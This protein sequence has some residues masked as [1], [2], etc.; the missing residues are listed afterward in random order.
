MGEVHYVIRFRKSLVLLLVASAALACGPAEVVGS[1]AAATRVSVRVEP[2]TALVAP[3]GSVEFKA[4]LTGAAPVALSWSADCGLVTQDGVYTAPPS[5]GTC[6]VTATHVAAGVSGTA[7]VSVGEGG[8]AARCATEPLRSTG[9]IYYACDCQT[10]AAAGCS[11]GND[12]NPGTSPGAPLRTLSAASSKFR[13]MNAGDTVALCAGGRFSAVADNWSA[14]VNLACTPSS[15]CILRD[16]PTAWSSERPVVAMPAAGERAFA[17][18]GKP[19]LVDGVRFLNLNLVGNGS[20]VG[21]GFGNNLS[22]WEFCNLRVQGFGSGVQ[23]SLDGSYDGTTGCP[24][25]P[26]QGRRRHF[27][28]NQIVDNASFGVLYDGHDSDWDGNYFDNN[29]FAAG[30]RCAAGATGHTFYIDSH[31]TAQNVRF[32]NNEVYR[33]AMY[34]GYPQGTSIQMGGGSMGMVI[35]NNFVDSGP[36]TPF[37]CTSGGIFAKTAGYGPTF[38]HELLVIRGNWLVRG[39][40]TQIGVSAAPD[41]LIENN[42]IVADGMSDINQND[43]ISLRSESDGLETKAVVRNNTLYLANISSASRRSGIAIASLDA[44]SGNIVTGNTITIV[45]EAGAPYSASC[46]RAADLSKIAFMNNNHCFGTSTYARVG[47]L[48]DGATSYTLESWRVLTGFDADSITADPMFTNA[49]T[50]LTPSAT[51]PLVGAAS[52][53]TCT[54]QGVGGQ[55]CSST[56]AGPSPTWNPTSRAETRTGSPFDIGAFER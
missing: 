30:N 50:D 49:P 34:N 16:Y 18:G 54:I 27:R 37:N 23:G 13:A 51:S 6:R 45:G 43:V 11:P 14:W 25:D 5:N 31:C 12:A 21:I 8:W 40:G 24:T 3:N 41:L 9:T 28:G 10:G 4:A 38:A 48:N 20:G 56:T 17:I 39:N 55:P 26:A 46:F 7:T 42:I 15:P 2:P 36:Q 53:T 29:A 22:D 47:V 35:E 32:I 44:Q 1:G 19:N 33:N 52:T